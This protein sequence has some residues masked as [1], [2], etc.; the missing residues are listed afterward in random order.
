MGWVE[1]G[2][3]PSAVAILTNQLRMRGNQVATP[4]A[5]VRQSGFSTLGLNN[6]MVTLDWLALAAN[7]ISDTFSIAWAVGNPGTFTSTSWTTVG[8][9]S[10]LGSSGYTLGQSF[11]LGAAAA[12]QTAISIMLFSDVSTGAAG[13]TEGFLIDNFVLSG[14]LIITPISLPSNMVLMLSGLVGLAAVGRRGRNRS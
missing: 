7:E 8:T 9:V 10:G 13:N 1:S 11:S 6:I 14:D 4:D 12:N 2:T 3:N 5:A